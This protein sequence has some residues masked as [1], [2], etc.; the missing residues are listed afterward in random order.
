MPAQFFCPW[1]RFSL[2]VTRR[3][4]PQPQNAP[5][6]QKWTPANVLAA[7][8]GDDMA[9]RLE[10]TR[11]QLCDLVWSTPLGRAAAIFS[12]SHAPWRGHSSS[13]RPP[14]FLPQ[15]S[16]VQP[17]RACRLTSLVKRLLWR[18][19]IVGRRSSWMREENPALRGRPARRTAGLGEAT[20]DRFRYGI[21]QSS[22]SLCWHGVTLCR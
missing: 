10:M 17:L 5:V 22:F 21:G 15:F 1:N 16:S 14:P 9:N 20:W 19:T 11:Q 2:W 6:S 12:M 8:R 18:R 3:E 4:V 13:R 7:R